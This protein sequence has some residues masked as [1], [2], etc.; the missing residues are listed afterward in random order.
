MRSPRSMGRGRDGAPGLP[1]PVPKHEWN[2]SQ[3]RFQKTDAT[4]GE[5]VDIRGQ[6]G[7]EGKPGG[8]AYEVALKAGFQGSVEDWLKSIEVVDGKSAYEIALE[9]G[10][11]GTVTEWLLSL[12]G[13]AGRD[14]RDGKDGEKGEKGE[15]GERG[16]SAYE[17]WL[18]NGNSGTE[19][20]F[21]QSI[22]NRVK[23][24]VQQLGGG[25]L[26]LK[27]G[28]LVDVDTQGAVNGNVL[29]FNGAEW[30]PG[31]GGS[32]GGAVD[33]V[34]G[35]T[36]IVV[37]DSDDIDEGST[38]LYFTDSERL[39]LAGIEENATE[40]QADSY[41]LDRANHTGT[42]TAST[43]SDFSS[44]A[45]A[46]ISAQKAQANGLA[47]LDGSGVIPTS[48]L[49]AL[50]ITQTF[51]VNSQAAQLALTAQEGDVAVRTDQNKSYIQ[52][53]ESSG[54][55]ADWQEL[56]TPTD[57]VLSV[58]GQTGAVTL[59]TTDIAEGI[60]LYFT[61]S[62]AKA[63]AVANTITDGV[64]D[65]APS[66]NA[67]FDALALKSPTD[68]PTFTGTVTAPNIL[69]TDAANQLVMSSGGVGNLI[70]T[71][72][73]TTGAN[74][75]I[76]IPSQ[77]GTIVYKN[78]TDTFTNK[79]I[80]G[81]SN[82]LTNIPQS[83]ITDLTTDLAAKAPLASPT[84]T[85]TVTLPAGQIVNGVTLTNAGSSTQYLNASGTYSTPAGGGT[86]DQI[87]KNISFYVPIPAS[88]SVT[89]IGLP[90]PTTTGTATAASV[91]ATNM[92]TMTRRVDYLQT[93][94]GTTNIVSFRA[95][96]LTLCLSYGFDVRIQWGPATGVSNSTHRAFC[97]LRGNTG[98]PTD[99]EPSTLT[100][101]IGMGWDA[102]DTNIQLMHND[103]A[104]TAAKVDLG[105]SL[106]VPSVDRTSVYE[107]RLFCAPGGSSVD[108]TVTDKATSSSVSGT[109]STELPGITQ[110]MTT[111]L[112][113]SVGGTS[114]IVGL[115]F[116]GV[117]IQTDY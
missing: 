51:V 25:S 53:G 94:P 7:E 39:K 12:K 68:S 104:G 98:A 85:G 46:R 112:Y 20:D 33:S 48:Q 17:V 37:L 106:P 38:N 73:A 100:N 82:T 28:M 3:I 47:T 76:Q 1:G 69:L 65:V 50:A 22:A 49:P 83:S 113:M 92:H 99:V 71:P 95:N 86:S 40:N 45:D 108:Y 44:S 81:A 87:A 15:Q 59:T 84:F 97:G 34:N 27:L 29:R 14:G 16:Y 80:D 91:Q 41:L 115:A 101:I 96:L 32:G 116:M 93:S 78:T 62:A 70:F 64:T 10:F 79:T 89:T 31:S 30:V 43:I 57:T 55:M 103:A 21:F 9:N 23:T 2:G 105:A 114:S 102:A 6:K 90:T 13:K 42:Q 11:T 111:M 109:L 52:N 36:G 67:V 54:T 61:D 77:S 75:T 35:Q 19:E 110:L 26:K 117:Y 72:T 24:K 5:W 60:N 107:L 4:W 58:N 8:D 88:T 56:L 18:L 74:R 63:A 66:Q